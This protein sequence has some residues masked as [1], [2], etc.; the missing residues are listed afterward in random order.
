[1]S[2]MPKSRKAEENEPR[3]KYLSEDSFERRS[4]RRNP[5]MT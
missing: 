2:A 5:A 1:M 4:V 3:M